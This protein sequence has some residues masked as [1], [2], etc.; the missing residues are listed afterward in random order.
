LTVLKLPGKL[1]KVR[2]NLERG[3]QTFGEC[4][5]SSQPWVNTQN[6]NEVRNFYLT[7]YPA[8][9]GVPSGWNGNHGNCNAGNTSAAF[10]TAV[11]RRIN[12]FRSMAGLP[13]VTA[14]KNDCNTNQRHRL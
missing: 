12:F 13:P 1:F 2:A 6:K 11:L 9:E 7:E 3:E 5:V 4:S 14:F 8:S 10:K